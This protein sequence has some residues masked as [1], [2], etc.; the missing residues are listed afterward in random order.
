MPDNVERDVGNEGEH[1]AVESTTAATKPWPR[2]GRRALIVAAALSAY[3]GFQWR[4]PALKINTASFAIVAGLYVATQA[5]ERVAEL[6]VAPWDG[7]RP[8]RPRFMHRLLRGYNGFGAPGS[9]TY[10]ANRTLFVGAVSTV[11][12]VVASGLLGIYF[13][14]TLTNQPG[15]GAAPPLPAVTTTTS[16]PNGGPVISQCPNAG[17]GTDSPCNN[18]TE[19]IPWH[20]RLAL[21]ADVFVTGL[22]FGGGTKVVHDLLERI[23]AKTA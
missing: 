1:N 5:I 6:V 14:S 18:K 11:L 12:G 10:K 19:G 3:F 20:S 8:R 16:L 9:A 15:D 23:S 4:Q 2:L 13:V 21:S 7:T 17:L 22:A